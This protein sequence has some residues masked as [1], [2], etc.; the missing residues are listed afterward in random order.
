M[1]WVYGVLYWNF[2]NINIAALFMCLTPPTFAFVLSRDVILG[3]NALLNK[4]Q[5]PEPG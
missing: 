3:M 2:A 4:K 5:G 1:G